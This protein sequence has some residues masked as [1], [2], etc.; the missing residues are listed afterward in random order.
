[1]LIGIALVIFSYSLTML[2]R[3]M[4]TLVTFPYSCHCPCNGYDRAFDDDY[5][6]ARSHADYRLP[7]MENGLF[8][9]AT[10]ATYGMPSW[11]N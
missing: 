8:F 9:A 10:S 3:E 7:A 5:K 11:L 1:M 2:V 4:S 6:E